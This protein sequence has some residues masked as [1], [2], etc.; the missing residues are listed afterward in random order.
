MEILVYKCDTNDRKEL[1]KLMQEEDGLSP[2]ELF[3]VA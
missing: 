1:S 2:E 3:V